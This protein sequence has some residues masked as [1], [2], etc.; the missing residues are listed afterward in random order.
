MIPQRRKDLLFLLAR[1]ALRLM[2]LYYRITWPS[3]GPKRSIHLGC[4]KDYLSSFLNAD[5]NPFRKI[6]LW[7]DLTRRLPAPD[8]AV[9]AIYSLETLEHLYPE[10][11]ERLLQDCRRVLKPGGRIRLGVPNLRRAVEA[12]QSGNLAWLQ[13]W[14]R[15]YRS[16]GGKLSNFLFCDG[17]HRMGFD[18]SLLEE[19]LTRAGFSEIEE[20]ARG[21][22]R[23]LDPS[24]LEL[25]EHS[26]RANPAALL[27]IEA[28]KL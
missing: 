10:E 21:K 6:D 25:E 22:S 27:Y 19:L 13:D 15:S 7:I 4:G 26:D 9:E 2:A 17:Q 18:F 16:V 14:P 20:T 12:Y 23:W 1:P 24:A 5:I 8:G 28:K 3:G 11:V